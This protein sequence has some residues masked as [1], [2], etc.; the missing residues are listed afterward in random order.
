MVFWLCPDGHTY[1]VN[2][3]VGSISF[4]A[5]NPVPS[6]PSG[7]PIAWINGTAYGL[8]SPLT[9]PSATTNAQVEI[10][11]NYP[12]GT[13]GEG[14]IAFFIQVCNNAA[15]T[16]SHV[17]DLTLNQ[18]GFV[19]DP[20]DGCSG[21][22]GGTWTPGS[23]WNTGLCEG[24]GSSR[25][26]LFI[27]WPFGGTVH[28]TAAQ[29]TFDTVLGSHTVNPAFFMQFD[30]IAPGGSDVPLET[31]TPSTGTNQF[32]T[33]PGAFDAIQ[34]GV[35]F[36]PDATVSPNHADGSARLWQMAV[37]GTGTDPFA[38]FP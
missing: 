22:M 14:N 6:A 12:S 2:D 5:T 3:C 16:W 4:D 11:L 10:G 23:G 8:S 13:S 18:G 31:V 9:V 7:S 26:A 32:L 30:S 29:I 17:I 38:G 36:S 20:V 24:G 15:T 28:F 21:A 35:Y 19:N 34:L 1:F 27:K 33:A 25:N 37:S